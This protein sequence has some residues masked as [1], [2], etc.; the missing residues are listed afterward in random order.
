MPAGNVLAGRDTAEIVA[1]LNHLNA[2]SPRA[3]DAYFHSLSAKEQAAVQDYLTTT[4]I[5]AVAEDGNPDLGAPPA[6]IQVPDDPD[7]VYAAAC[8][9]PYTH[10]VYGKN[11][12]GVT[13]FEY[14]QQIQWCGGS[15]ITGAWCSAWNAGTAW[16]FSFQGHD[17]YCS[18]TYGGIGFSSI[19]YFSQGTYQF[20]AVW[21]DTYS[22]GSA[23]QGAVDGG[24]WAWAV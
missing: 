3:A 20:C 10:R 18:V 16:G 12:L 2:R 24:Y 7:A 15:S 19:K 9:G 8:Y 17:T 22:P 14:K 13:T 23:Q 6:A 4:E 21:C 11:R 1:K 5:V